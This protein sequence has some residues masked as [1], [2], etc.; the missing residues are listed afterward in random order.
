MLTRKRSHK[1][2][3]T[4]LVTIWNNYIKMNKIRKTQ[5]T[6]RPRKKTYGVS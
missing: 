4:I 1:P 2:Q 6:K 5:K 3:V